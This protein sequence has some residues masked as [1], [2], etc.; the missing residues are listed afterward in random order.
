MP[1]SGPVGAGELTQVPQSP[2]EPRS[3]EQELNI[4]C[5]VTQAAILFGH[6]SCI[7]GAVWVA[8]RGLRLGYPKF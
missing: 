7:Q 6:F 5:I 2:C 3:S 8:V 1:L 4:C